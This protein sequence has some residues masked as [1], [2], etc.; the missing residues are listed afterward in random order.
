MLLLLEEFFLEFF[1]LPICLLLLQEALCLR[2]VS[3]SDLN[4][5]RIN[6]G[7]QFEAD[8]SFEGV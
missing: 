2:L 6:A 7:E 3:H 1:N 5:F 4:V 8:H